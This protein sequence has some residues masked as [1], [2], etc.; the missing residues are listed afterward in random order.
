MIYIVNVINM[1]RGEKNKLTKEQKERIKSLQGVM[2]AYLIA[3]D[4]GI[5]HTMVYKL[6]KSKVNQSKPHIEVPHFQD[7]IDEIRREGLR[8]FNLAPE[9]LNDKPYRIIFDKTIQHIRRLN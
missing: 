7:I 8:G 1:P 5:S 4:F 2:G 3:E 9:K 6:W